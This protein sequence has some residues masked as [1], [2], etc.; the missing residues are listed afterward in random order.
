MFKEQQ[1][2]QCDCNGVKQGRVVGNE[3]RMVAEGQDHVDSYIYY[4]ILLGHQ[5]SLGVE[6]MI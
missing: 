4:F 5:V 3:V 2:S 1:G 6:H